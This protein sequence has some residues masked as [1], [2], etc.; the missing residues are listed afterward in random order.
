MLNGF[1]VPPTVS[2]KRKIS[3]ASICITSSKLQRKNSNFSPCCSLCSFK[4]VLL[5]VHDINKEEK[6]SW[7]KVAVKHSFPYPCFDKS[8]GVHDLMLLEVS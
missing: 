1:L 7:Q 6:K 2:G 5:G 4:E 3:F 8:E